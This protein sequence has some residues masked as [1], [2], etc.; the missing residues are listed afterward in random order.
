MNVKT[1]GR[2]DLEDLFKLSGVLD[3]PNLKHTP[4]LAFVEQGDDVNV[5]IVKSAKALLDLPDETPVMVQWRGEW[6]SDFFQMT[7]GDVRAAL[8]ARQKPT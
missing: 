3:W 8:E 2:T 1:S 4:F 5:V 6:R 7:V